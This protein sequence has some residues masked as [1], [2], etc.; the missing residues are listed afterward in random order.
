MGLSLKSWAGLLALSALASTFL[1][2]IFL[3][4]RLDNYAENFVV[5]EYLLAGTPHWR[6]FQNRLLGPLIQ[7][8]IEYTGRILGLWHSP[9]AAYDVYVFV[10]LTGVAF[11]FALVGRARFSG[12]SERIAYSLVLLLCYVLTQDRRW[13]Y[14]WDPLDVMVFSVLY[15]LIL[16]R[17]PVLDY[18]ILFAV[19]LANRETAI[20]IGLWLV[21]DSVTL[22][23]GAAM[24]KGL[25]RFHI[26]AAKAASGLAMMVS[27]EIIVS[28]IRTSLFKHNYDLHHVGVTVHDNTGNLWAVP[29]NIHTLSTSLFF[30]S[31]FYLPVFLFIVLSVAIYVYRFA[32]FRK[33]DL[34]DLKILLLGVSL[35]ASFVV[36]SLIDEIR[37]LNFAIPFIIHAAM[38]GRGP[39]AP[40][41]ERGMAAAAGG[42]PT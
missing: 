38:I 29:L 14:P 41:S 23:D 31:I 2:R 1:T 26:S 37:A 16:K 10:A 12:T 40:E 8:G 34:Y 42:N 35:L 3:L 21:I 19:A 24:A 18:W 39:R 13:F 30:T 28:F 9:S 4:L 33:I 11:C 27:C 36:F 17:R 20:A 5:S 25:A 15:I 6:G 32:N 7:Q 22:R